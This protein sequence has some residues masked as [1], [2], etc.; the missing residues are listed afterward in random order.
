MPAAVDVAAYRIMQEALTNVVR[1]AQAHTCVVRLTHGDALIV[2]VRD[3]GV[4]LPPDGRAG[5]GLMSMRERSAELGG[6][7][8]IETA[9]GG[10]TCVRVELPLHQ[11][12]A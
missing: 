6:T 1:H 12:G 3:D 5:V 9:P 11:E 7:C 10:G 2:A 8:L 4:G